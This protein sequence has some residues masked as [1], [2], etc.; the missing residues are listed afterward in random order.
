MSSLANKCILLGITGGIAAY[1]SAELVRGLRTA[2]ATVRVVMTEA[3]T[4]FITPLTLQA[5]SG[6]P[7]RT[8]LLDPAAEAAMDHIELARWADAVLVAPASANFIAKLAHGH[9]DDL[10]ST[11]CLASTAPCA[12][13][14]AMNHVMW[15][16]A[17]TVANVQ[18]LR[19]RGVHIY[20]PA[21]GDLACGESG[22]G[23][24]LEPA[25]LQQQLGALFATGSLSGTRVLVSAGPTREAIDAVRFISNRSSGKMGYA[26]A[27]AAVEAGAQVTL[28]SG[29]V[30]LA[31]PAH[32]QR[33]TVQNAQAMYDA[34]LAAAPACDIFVAAAAVADYRPAVVQTDKLKK[35][36]AELTLVLQRT[37]DILASVAALPLAPFTVGFAAET[38]ELIAHAQA[39]RA[40]KALDMIAANWVGRPDGGFDSDDNALQVF[41]A[42]G[43]V[44]LALASKARV[45]RQ[46]VAVIAERYRLKRAPH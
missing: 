35:T 14:P 42:D 16:N 24:M 15:T 43:G 8:A 25:Q 2:G 39:K 46:L 40:A 45:A 27:T 26:V 18:L 37:P 32:V 28:V 34:V 36:A 31:A 11:L 29:P 41:W 30:A 3:A 12:L 44:E 6:H 17:A 5:L 38:E 20:G 10:L 23:R 33:I 13:A 19:A 7:V 9:A 4:R 1:K 22:P 21:A